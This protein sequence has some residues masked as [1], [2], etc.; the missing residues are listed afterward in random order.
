MYIARDKNG[1]FNAFILKP[2]RVCNRVFDKMPTMWST[3]P[4]EPAWSDIP[5]SLINSLGIAELSEMTWESEPIEVNICL[6]QHQKI[7]Y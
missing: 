7:G 6:E 2:E 4:F 3:R 1:E 5:M